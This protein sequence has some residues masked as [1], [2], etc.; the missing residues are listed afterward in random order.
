MAE[1]RLKLEKQPGVTIA[2]FRDSSILDVV[3]IQ[4]I[5][6]ELGDVVAGLGTGKLVL[7]FT[8]V[9]FLS[10]QALGT[11]VSLQRQADS[12]GA[13]VVLCS[14]RP[15][16]VRIFKITN[17]D[18]VFRFF[19]GRAEALEHLGVAPAAGA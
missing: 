1:T 8:D 7:D 15:E 9:R 3:T 14:I 4:Q 11:L 13:R 19:G 2:S 17:L 16:I 12:V 5:G 18:K 10:S 6:K